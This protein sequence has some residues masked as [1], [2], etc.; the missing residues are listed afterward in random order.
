MVSVSIP[1]FFAGSKVYKSTNAGTNWTNISGSLPN[2][3]TGAI[4]LYESIPGG[5]FVGTDAGVYYRDNSLADWQ[6]YGEVPHTRVEDIEIQYSGKL[7][8]IGTHGRGVLEAPIII[9]TCDFGD[10]EGFARPRVC[11]RR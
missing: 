11:Q 10:P 4:E 2:V 9:E 8:R 3:S 5:I 6:E 1:G 7:V